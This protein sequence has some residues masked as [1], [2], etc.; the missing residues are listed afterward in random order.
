M[1][2]KLSVAATDLGDG[3]APDLA[4]VLERVVR[5]PATVSGPELGPPEHPTQRPLLA[6]AKR[7]HF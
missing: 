2:A 5:D 4:L 6:V 3:D 1:V 7:R